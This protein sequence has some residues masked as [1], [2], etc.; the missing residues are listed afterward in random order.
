MSENLIHRSARALNPDRP[1]KAFAEKMRRPR[2]TIKSWMT[3]HRR[4][5]IVT[6]KILCGLLKDRQAVLYQL[7]PELEYVIMLREREPIHC[8]GFNLIDPL[9]GMDKRN[10]LGRPKRV[11]Q[12]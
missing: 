7:I 5:P 10:R 9:T 6:L 1:L 2:S 8:T 3:G 4:P 12:F 11:K